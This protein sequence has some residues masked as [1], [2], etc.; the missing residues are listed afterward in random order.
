MR[1]TG[2]RPSPLPACPALTSQAFGTQGFS[3]TTASARSSLNSSAAEAQQDAAAC[4]SAISAFTPRPRP[5]EIE[6]DGT[7]LFG[8]F[9]GVPP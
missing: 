1:T 6:I 9:R 7:G 5:P 8:T 4:C 3:F 2:N